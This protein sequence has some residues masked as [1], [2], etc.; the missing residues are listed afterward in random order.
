MEGPSF[1]PL[2]PPGAPIWPIW[3]PYRGPTGAPIGYGGPSKGPLSTR[4]FS[5]LVPLL[6]FP[7]SAFGAHI[8]C[9]L[10]QEYE[11][12][13]KSPT[14]MLRSTLKKLAG[15]CPRSV[16]LCS[17]RCTM[18]Q[19]DARNPN[20]RPEWPDSGQKEPKFPPRFKML[21]PAEGQNPP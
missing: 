4:P 12:L 8:R 2:G 1:T 15:N 16:G 5:L 13:H 19:N 14:I 7:P 9:L 20:P 6:F 17:Y 3:G 21:S 18:H 11:R 10:N